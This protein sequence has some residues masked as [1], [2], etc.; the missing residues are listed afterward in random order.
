[1]YPGRFTV[2]TTKAPAHRDCYHEIPA[3]TKLR[4][5]EPG[6]LEYS[7]SEE[8][9]RRLVAKVRADG[10][11]A[12]LVLL[13]HP[14]TVTL[15]RGAHAENLRVP[16][17]EMER[18]GVAVAESRRGGDVT[19]HG[20]GQLVGYSILRLARPDLH[21]YLRAL[22]ETLIRA[23][24]DIGLEARRAPPYTGVWTERGKIAAIG[25]AVTSRLV[26]YHGFAL[27]V[28][29]GPDESGLIVPCGI[30]DRPVTCVSEALGSAP[31]P[32]AVRRAVV[33]RYAEVFGLR[34]VGALDKLGAVSPWRRP[35]EGSA[36]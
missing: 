7:A 4:L 36:T 31:D 35:L 28:T 19:Y 12:Y 6:R 5:V 29:T 27:N 15:G 3:S 11:T 2:L 18:R 33:R 22:E 23:L 26:T 21:G 32:A 10:S 24:A 14:P 30:A 8:L 17:A 9:Q 16:I 13:E 20:P 34:L 25:V 1:V